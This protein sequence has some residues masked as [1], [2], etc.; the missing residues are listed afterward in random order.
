[1]SI[2]SLSTSPLA[3]EVRRSTS[4]L[5]GEVRRSRGGG[6]HLS[7]R[8]QRR[9]CFL[10]E[11]PLVKLRDSLQCVDLVDRLVVAD[12]NDAGKAERVPAFVACGVLDGIE[13]NLEHDLRIDKAPVPLIVDGDLEE[14]LCAG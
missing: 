14:T 1:M 7:Y 6:A 3:G 2:S 12:P 4:P 11:V 5:A 13:R 8:A 10:P 9:N